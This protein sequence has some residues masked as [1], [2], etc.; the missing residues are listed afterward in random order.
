MQETIWSLELAYFTHFHAAEYEQMLAL[1]HPAFL[2][3]PDS[4]P[5][6]LDRE[7]SA[8]FMRKAATSP[9]ACNIRLERAGIEIQGNVSLTQYVVHVQPQGS[10]T[11]HSSRICHTWIREGSDWKLL[12]GMSRDL[13][14]Q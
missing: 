8:A 13:E 2:G 5:S 9:S 4:L 14:P 11:T 1:V 7:G 3:W 12:G 6:P 10:A